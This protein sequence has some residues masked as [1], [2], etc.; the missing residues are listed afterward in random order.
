M[1][2]SLL[3]L[4]HVHGFVTSVATQYVLVAW[5]WSMMVIAE[6]LA[7]KKTMCKMLQALD[8]I[9]TRLLYWWKSKIVM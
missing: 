3:T 4:H 5:K 1:Q 6:H 2:M 8:R 9:H 7:L